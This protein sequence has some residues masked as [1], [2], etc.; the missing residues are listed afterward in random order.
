MNSNTLQHL[1]SK[2]L[3]NVIHWSNQDLK[4]ITKDVLMHYFKAL[5][6]IVYLPSR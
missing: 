5:L 2:A 6:P 1:G 3:E 4:L